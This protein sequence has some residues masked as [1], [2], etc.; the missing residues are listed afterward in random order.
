MSEMSEKRRFL[1]LL[2]DEHDA[3]GLARLLNDVRVRGAE[4]LAEFEAP[5]PGGADYLR[6]GAAARSDAVAKDQI[7]ILQDQPGLEDVIPERAEAIIVGV[8]DSSEAQ[9]FAGLPGVTTFVAAGPLDFAV[10]LMERFSGPE[11]PVRLFDPYDAARMRALAS[12]FP[13]DEVSKPVS[14]AEERLEEASQ[15]LSDGRSEDALRVFDELLVEN[16]DWWKAHLMRGRA[17]RKIADEGDDRLLPAGEAREEAMAAFHAALD[18]GA[19]EIDEIGE[20]LLGLGD[21]AGAASVFRR[22]VDQRPDAPWLYNW[23]GTA[24]ALDE[25]LD[26][27]FEQACE[28]YTVGLKQDPTDTRVLVNRGVA[29]VNLCR[30]DAALEDL[31]RARELQ[32]GEGPVAQM[33]RAVAL[34]ALG[35]LREAARAAAQASRQPTERRP[36]WIAYVSAVAHLRMDD[37]DRAQDALGRAEALTSEQ[38]EH[39][40]LLAKIR[41]VRAVILARLGQ[42][43]HAHA[44]CDAS[45]KLDPTEPVPYATRAWMLQREDRLDDAMAA[46]ARAV[47]LVEADPEWSR[48]CRYAGARWPFYVI[49]ASVLNALSER[50][51]DEELAE[52][53]I[54][55]TARGL[56][57]FEILDHQPGR[58]TRADK[59]RAAQIFLERAYA[60]I[61]SR[62]PVQAIAALRQARALAPPRST[63]WFAATRALRAPTSPHIPTWAI[64][65]AEG[66]AI[67][68]SV[69]LLL[70]GRLASAAF[71][72]LV[73]GVVTLGLVAFALP[74]ITRLGLGTLQ[75]EKV[76]AHA[77]AQSLPRLAAPLPAPAIPMPPPRA[78]LPE[79]PPRWLPD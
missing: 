37:L 60:S 9:R 35:D 39:L 63:P 33:Y 41:A 14:H 42:F 48:N 73:I 23:L 27:R 75:L 8:S 70:F 78:R 32:G 72:T 16:P 76:V 58:C 10:E 5:R 31:N 6:S 24:L 52:H 34:G 13:V 26:D 57:D 53:A 15:E 62:D 55:A 71:A 18:A 20:Q 36:E 61:L 66:L 40:A 59:E 49:Q 46:V 3:D 7:L 19:P 79:I 68:G 67:A 4:Q 11:A 74:Y 29:Y 38:D 22:A 21:Y 12:D 45:I 54:E 65:S 50:Y 1:V 44:M 64:V 77:S 25:Q 43:D 69:A 47:E 28:A 30:Y 51:A 56:E 2:E 17:L